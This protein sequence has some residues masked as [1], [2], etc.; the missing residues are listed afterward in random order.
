MNAGSDWSFLVAVIVLIFGPVCVATG[1]TKAVAQAPD[2]R[3][4]LAQHCGSCHAIGRD[5]ASPLQGAPA[6]REIYLRFPNK[7]LEALILQ[8]AVSHY[9]AMPQIEFS[10]ADTDAIM[11]YLASIA[12]ELPGKK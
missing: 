2:G 8:G 10:L 3:M 1:G 9:N 4:L 6:F 7:Q 12:G 5:D 11:T